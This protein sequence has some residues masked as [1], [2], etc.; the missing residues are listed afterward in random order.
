MFVN[1]S[2]LE[3]NVPET[4]R[5]LEFGQNAIDKWNWGRRPNMSP[6]MLYRSKTIGSFT[7]TE[8]TMY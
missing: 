5:T 1:I 2:P 3:S 4:I 6:D 7:Y 8:V